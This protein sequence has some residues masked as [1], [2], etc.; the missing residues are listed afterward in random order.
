MNKYAFFGGC[1][2]PPTVAHKKCAEVILE[3]LKLDKVFFVPVGNG[4]EKKEL[5]DE[6]HRYEMLKLVCNKN[7]KLDVCDIELNQNKS[8]KAIDIFKLIKNIYKDDEI[9]FIIGADNFENILNW[10]DSLELISNY[11][12]ILLNRNN[13][14]LQKLIC[15]NNILNKYS[16]NFYCINNIEQIDVSSTFI[17]NKI[18]IEKIELIK[19]MIDENVLQYIEENRLYK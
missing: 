18:R 9:Y 6:K 8:F 1:F 19:K 2:N 13:I 15:T 11:K 12:F 10:K 17:R 16:S 3:E 14:D 7:E 5:I 4:Y